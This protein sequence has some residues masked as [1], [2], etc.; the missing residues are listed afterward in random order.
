MYLTPD[1]LRAR[2]V[3]G[4]DSDLTLYEQYARELIDRYT[5][6]HFDRYAGT[7]NISGSGSQLLLLPDWLSSLTAVEINNEDV[8]SAYTFRI[9]GYALYC[10]DAVFPR[11]FKNILV[12]GQWGR[13]SEVP[14]V[15]KEA[16]VELTK[17]QQDPTRVDK[18]FIESER[19]GDY[20]YKRARS[21]VGS[22]SSRTTGNPKVDVLLKHFVVSCPILS[23]PSGTDSLGRTLT[24]DQALRRWVKTL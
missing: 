22:G 21:G 7:I 5:R 11:G 15:V 16:V 12:T 3:S 19:L 23:S 8:T 13:Y 17:D 14:E 6:T 24:E 1:E 20:S 2:G 9:S 18:N 10:E 4:T